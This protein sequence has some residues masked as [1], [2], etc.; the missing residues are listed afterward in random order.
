[1]ITR[2]TVILDRM[3]LKLGTWSEVA[4]YLE[5]ARVT[6]WRWRNGSPMPK[7][8]RIWLELM[9]MDLMNKEK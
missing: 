9:A 1:M 5:V 7:K 6:V 3:R 2:H 4:R 8:T